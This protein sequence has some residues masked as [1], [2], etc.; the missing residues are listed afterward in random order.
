FSTATISVPMD[1]L[2]SLVVRAATTHTDVS[3]DLPGSPSVEHAIAIPTDSGVATIVVAPKSLL[4]APDPFAR[5]FGIEST[6]EVEPPY[7]VQII[8][9]SAGHVRATRPLWRREANELH[10]DWITPSGSGTSRVHVEVELRP[11]YALVQR[12]TLLVLL[13][14]AIVGLLWLTSVL[15]DGIAVRWISVRQR[16]LARSYR[17]RLT[18]ALFAFFMVP[19]IAFAVWS[20]QQLSAD[21]TR[22]RELLV[23]E[24]LRSATP[25]GPLDQWL[26][27]ES[28][29]L[30]T[31]LF[32][33]NGGPLE[34][35][36]DTLL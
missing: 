14:L 29:R 31:P 18:F 21:A 26:V 1:S 6:P 4:I 19:A 35:A 8:A 22:A 16:R 12:G 3:A 30:Q 7:V 5:L 2:R 25:S 33:Y 27:R 9:I 20:Y 24:T 13:N 15:A 23:R 10:G 11:L 36:S 32:A 28:R 34:S 17:I